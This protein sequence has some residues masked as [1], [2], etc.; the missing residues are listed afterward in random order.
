[1][2]G[3]ARCA[4]RT[5]QRSVPTQNPCPSVVKKCSRGS[6]FKICVSSVASV[7]KLGAFVSWWLK[8]RV[9]LWF[10]EEMPKSADFQGFRPVTAFHQIIL[11]PTDIVLTFHQVVLPPTDIVLSFHQIVLPP[12]DIVVSLHQ[13][14]LPP[15]DIVLPFHQ[16]VLSPNNIVVSLHQIV[17][18]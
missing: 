14:V 8:L 1:M 7:A 12:N 10:T 4:D 17:L 2:V 16:F 13:V 15:T 3:S 11:S 9:H 6:R 5:P 18:P